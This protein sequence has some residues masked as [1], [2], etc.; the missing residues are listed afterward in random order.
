MPDNDV[1]DISLEEQESVDGDKFKKRYSKR[2]NITEEDNFKPG[3]RILDDH[4]KS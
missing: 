2:A 1:M 3:P 4:N